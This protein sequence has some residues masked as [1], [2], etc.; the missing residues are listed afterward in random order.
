LG[1]LRLQDLDLMR[2]ELSVLGKGSVRRTVPVLSDL[3][4]YL[5]RWV[6]VRP[7]VDHDF[8]FTT[9]AGGPL[10]DK[11]CWRLFKRP[12]RR[13][14]LQDTGYT[15]HSLRHGAA[16]Q[17]YEAGVD[18]GTIARFL[19][20]SDMSTVGRYVHAGTEVIRRQIEE[21]MRGGELARIPAP[22][23]PDEL[24]RVVAQV[25]VA[26][27]QTLCL[28]EGEEGPSQLVL[29]GNRIAGRW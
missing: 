19:R 6:A 17:M 25:V 15:V 28:P 12:L 24:S 20:H 10:Y 18:L 26:V 29:S 22:E 14:N 9:R 5:V 23:P 1:A 4:P 8:L 21:R 11:A 27:L 16:T 3:R 7:V 13:A 2:N